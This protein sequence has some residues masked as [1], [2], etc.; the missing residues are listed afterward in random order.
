MVLGMNDSTEHSKR[1][2]LKTY[3]AIG[4]SREGKSRAGRR[5][6]QRTGLYRYIGGDCLERPHLKVP[7]E[8]YLRVW[9][10]SQAIILEKWKKSSLE[11]TAKAALMRPE[12]ERMTYEK[13]AS[14]MNSMIAV[15]TSFQ[16]S[17]GRKMTLHEKSLYGRT[18]Q[19]SES[20]RDDNSQ[21]NQKRKL[22]L[23]HVVQKI[24]DL[25]QGDTNQ[26]QAAWVSVVGPETA[27]ESILESIDPRTGI[28]FCRC[29]N[30][31]LKF[32]MQ[33]TRDLSARLSQAL[34][35]KIQ[36]ILFR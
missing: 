9:R 22:A 33:R 15:E 19:L 6:A 2:E 27:L 18:L 31:T 14:E 8:A 17:E 23:N 30:P 13:L 3:R 32:Q 36:K 26:L 20:T 28:A 24:F 1:E 11:A 25:H 16:Q 29:N 34:G 4:L 5:K 35:R 12:I 7:R 21:M 10:E